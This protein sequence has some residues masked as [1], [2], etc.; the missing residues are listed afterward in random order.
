ME[1]L[2]LLQ[3]ASV[4]LSVPTPRHVLGVCLLLPALPILVSEQLVLINLKLDVCPT[5]VAN[6]VQ[7]F[8]IPVATMLQLGVLVCRVFNHAIMMQKLRVCTHT[9]TKDRQLALMARHLLGVLL[10]LALSILVLE[11]QKPDV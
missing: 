3:T 7:N 2:L 5:S 4:V 6:A 9:H 11:F 1:I 10:I 8:M